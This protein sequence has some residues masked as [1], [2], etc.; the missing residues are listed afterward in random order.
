MEVREREEG[1]EVQERE[2]GVRE[3]EKREWRCEREKREL[4]RERNNPSTHYYFSQMLYWRK[5]NLSIV[6]LHCSSH[7]PSPSIAEG[8]IQY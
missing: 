5:L 8:L 2:E 3:G 4:E 1:V 6:R 7:Y